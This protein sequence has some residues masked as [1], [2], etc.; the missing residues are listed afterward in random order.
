M[1]KLFLS[2]LLIVGLGACTGAQVQNAQN[3]QAIVQAALNA[4]CSNPTIQA[5]LAAVVPGGSLGC[6]GGV[7]GASVITAIMNDPQ[8]VAQ[9]EAL[10]SRR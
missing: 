10:A 4:A 5:A 7:A 2:A 9:V 8:L 6:A 1:R 3:D